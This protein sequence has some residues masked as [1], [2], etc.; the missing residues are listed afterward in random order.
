MKYL[1][2]NFPELNDKWYLANLKLIK[3]NEKI[4]KLDL[5]LISQIKN[6]KIVLFNLVSK[7]KNIG[8]LIFIKHEK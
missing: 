3:Y 4:E 7:K 1:K 5:V 8:E 6:K 2:L